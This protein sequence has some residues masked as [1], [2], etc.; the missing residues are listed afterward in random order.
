M[1]QEILEF[2]NKNPDILCIQ[3]FS[4]SAVID[5]KC[6]FYILMQGNKIKTGQAI[7]LNSHNKSRRYHISQF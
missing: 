3:E 4:S 5:L 7:F 6:T 1:F 2:I